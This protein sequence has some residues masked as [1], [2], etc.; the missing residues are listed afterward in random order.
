MF[1]DGATGRLWIEDDDLNPVDV[2][3]GAAPAAAGEIAVDKGLAKK[4]D[5]AV[6][7][8]VTLL[9][10]AGPQEVTIVGITKFGNSDSIDGGSG[11]VSISKENAF[12]W[13]SSGQVEYQSLYVRGSGDQAALVVAIEPSAPDGFKVQDGESFLDDKRSE[14]GAPAQY[15]KKALQA[16]ALLAM[17]VG[18]FVIYNTF[19][20]IVSQRLRELAVM[21]A[22]GATPKQIKR[23]LR[24]EGVVIGVLG[25][26]L[27]LLVGFVLTYALGLA[28]TAFGVALPG[29]G[30]KIGL[31]NVVSAVLIGTRDHRR[32]GHDPGTPC[33]EDRADRG[34]P[35]RRRRAQPVLARPD[36]RRPSSSSAVASP[37][38]CS[39]PRPRCSVSAPSRSSSA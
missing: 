31:T 35:R 29:S 15:L 37:G 16:F 14:I 11:T 25:S 17:L 21:S 39:A 36:H 38:S 27:G 1:A 30:A 7:D 6:G 24:Y 22:I 2:E 33:R 8:K 28:L 3:E 20:V 18:G 5:L 9:T 32:L 19:S 23:A 4:H 12:D 13:L 34:A 26:L 10:L